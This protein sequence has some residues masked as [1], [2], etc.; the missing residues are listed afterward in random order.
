MEWLDSVLKTLNTESGFW[1]PLVWILI[2]IVALV[3]TYLIRSFGKTA[4]KKGT[5]QTKPF[6]SGNPE[7]DKE[8]SHVKASNLYWGFMES[9]KMIYNILTKIHTGNV[10]DYVMWFVVIMGIFFILIVGVF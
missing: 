9:M 1:N 4:Y 2:I 10:G 7:G 3:I 6:L 8:K 5:E